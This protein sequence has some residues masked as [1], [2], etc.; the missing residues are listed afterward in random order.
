MIQYLR[1][2]EKQL[3]LLVP[4]LH[5]TETGIGICGNLS[6]EQYYAGTGI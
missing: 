3:H 1:S 2:W 5:V 6:E 4:P